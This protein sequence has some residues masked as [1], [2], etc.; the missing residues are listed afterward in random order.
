MDVYELLKEDHRKV[1]R[2]LKKLETTSSRAMKS[3]ARVFLELK[4]ELE[5]HAFVE[6]K[7]FYPQ[8]IDADKTAGITLEG[9]EE[10]RIIKA[11]LE[12]MDDPM[13]VNDEWLA[14]LHVL[15]E[16]IE[17]HVKEEEREMFKKAQAVITDEEAIKIGA[18]IATEK[19]ELK[20]SA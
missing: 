17:H 13:L 19:A 7:L 3:R 9:Y 10:H 18:S 8:L 20:A 16:K 2:L 12:E 6:E 15:K 1:A 14:K 11:L 4:Q 5:M